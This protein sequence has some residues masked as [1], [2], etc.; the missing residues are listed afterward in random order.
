MRN[1]PTRTLLAGSVVGVGAFIVSL[2]WLTNAVIAKIDAKIDA[3]IPAEVVKPEP[4]APHSD[5][6]FFL[7][8]A[9][10]ALALETL[11]LAESNVPL[12]NITEEFG[13]RR[14]VEELRTMSQADRDGLRAWLHDMAAVWFTP[15][16]KPQA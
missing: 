7:T 11:D 10:I 6:A 15:L 1:I 8:P 16:P 9:E 5:E 14:A 2:G 4:P 3:W 12:A 13:T